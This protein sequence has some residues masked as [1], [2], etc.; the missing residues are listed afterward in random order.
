MDKWSPNSRIIVPTEF[1]STMHDSVIS[2]NNFG[3]QERKYDIDA[4]CYAAALGVTRCHNIDFV[5]NLELKGIW[6]TPGIM[7]GFLLCRPFFPNDLD[8]SFCSDMDA[9]GIPIKTSNYG[10]TLE[11][12]ERLIAM[13][14]RYCPHSEYADYHFMW[15]G[16]RDST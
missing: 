6:Y 3:G 13:F 10:S 16:S 15:R 12:D 11:S 5:T 7:S 2:S 1:L 9:I 4:N 14:Y 8:D